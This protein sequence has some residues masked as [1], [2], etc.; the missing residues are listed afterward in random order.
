MYHIYRANIRLVLPAITQNFLESKD[1]SSPIM[2][3]TKHS[4]TPTKNKRILHSLHVLPNA[5]Y[6]MMEPKNHVYWSNV[7]LDVAIT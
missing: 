7:R 3:P 4:S 5:Y 1:E 6:E 2:D